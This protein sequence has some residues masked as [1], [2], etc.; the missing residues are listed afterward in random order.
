MRFSRMLFVIAL[1][2]A[3]SQ[4]AGAQELSKRD[5]LK[6]AVQGIC[7]VSGQKLGD[8]GPPIKVKIGEEE[9]FL[10]CK[11]CLQ[12]QVN[13]KHWGT[14]HANFA[15]AQGKCPVM[16]KALPKTPKWTIVNGQIVYI[17]CPPC[18]AKIKADPAK[19]LAKVDEYYSASLST[20]R[21][22]R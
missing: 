8:H 10:C 4:F 6:V 17:C 3:T 18:T 9:V 13:P 14:I 15:A 7:P 5:Q 12:G 20:R 1:V 11:G 19:F 22:T 16:E 21:T 2:A